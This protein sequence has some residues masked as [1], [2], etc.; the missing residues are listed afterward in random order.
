MN[1]NE[2]YG[3]YYSSKY[4][5]E[6]DQEGIKP[7]DYHRY[8]LSDMQE[9][10]T[11]SP[12]EQES[13]LTSMHTIFHE[14]THLVHD[15]TLGSELL[16]DIL[17]DSICGEMKANIAAA[18]ESGFPLRLPLDQYD[19]YSR[20][21][22]VKRLREAYAAIYNSK[23]LTGIEGRF[24]EGIN[25]ENIL[26]SL[27]VLRTCNCM[28][29]AQPESTRGNLANSRFDIEQMP[30]K[31]TRLWSIY[32]AVLGSNLGRDRLFDT[33][34]FLLVC[35]IALHIPCLVSGAGEGGKTYGFSEAY[36]PPMRFYRAIETLNQNS[37]FPDAVEGTDFY[38]TLFDFFAERNGWPTFEQTFESWDR[39]FHHRMKQGFMVSDGYK[40]I[41]ANYK[42]LVPTRL[43]TRLPGELICRLGLPA[44]IKYAMQDRKSF[45]EYAFAFLPSHGFE[46]ICET[47]DVPESPL[48]DPYIIMEQFRNP[49]SL[50]SF[51]QALRMESRYSWSYQASFPFLRE[52]L[53]RIISKDFFK[54]VESKTSFSCPVAGLHC[55]SKRVACRSLKRLTN[56]PDR[57]CLEM[58][59]R[60]SGI[61]KDSIYWG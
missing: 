50:T 12:K 2:P 20:D 46:R 61:R 8:L 21:D 23:T 17:Y 44:L 34:S 47:E 40:L 55:R 1:Y 10:L 42:K 53:C 5:I 31:Y 18:S 56:L 9:L 43:I 35:D 48:Q 39:F 3:G 60:E 45:L 52:I 15:F 19:F 57:C 13:I 49:W 16:K 58:W 11:A 4:V 29:F 7:G 22:D 37:G 54:A 41:S 26:E 6:F 38:I 28:F 59:L 33:T 25:T 14:A 36:L 51:D 30:E 32:K 27:V 24:M